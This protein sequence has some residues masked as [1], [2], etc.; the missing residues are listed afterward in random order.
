MR[1]KLKT[2]YD[3]KALK[4]I[5]GPAFIVCPHVSNIDFL[6]VAVALLPHRPTFVVSQHFMTHPKIR[7]IL[8]KMHVIPKKMFCPDIKTILSIMRAKESGNL[9]VLFPEGRLT[10]FGHSL[11][12][13]DGTAE[14]VKKLEIPVYMISEDGA[15]K[16]F[17]KW[18]RSGFR[19]G[20]ILVRAEKLLEADAIPAM[21]LN[22]VQ[23]V[24]E[25]AILHDEDK[26][27]PDVRYRCESPALGLD[28]IL[29]KCPSCL[30]EFRMET[31]ARHIRCTACGFEAE[32]DE[33][34]RLHG[35]P[36][37]HINDWY[38][39]QESLLD[40]AIPLESETVLA[41]VGPDGNMDKMQ[42][43]VASIWTAMSSAIPAPALASRLPLPK[44][45][46][47][48]KRFRLLSR[49]TLISTTKNSSTI[50][51][52]DRIRVRLSNG[53]A[54]WTSSRASGKL[55]QKTRKQ[56]PKTDKSCKKAFFLVKL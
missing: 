38:F 47:T 53:S 31:D 36:F 2:R 6:L 56:I 7:W 26:I 25:R 55:P 27:F 28:G 34:Y 30:A 44:R 9:I 18:G 19:P 40:L 11:Q 5:R 20:R 22:E 39:W 52:C 42:E 23:A 54:I 46:K 41:A 10:C 1:F 16:T 15:Y 24:L 43:Q 13:T 49:T 17:P 33:T 12:V 8:E 37:T 32:L 21:S 14:L 50:C 48:S 3:I 51:T 4:G 29:Y 45:Q 35:A